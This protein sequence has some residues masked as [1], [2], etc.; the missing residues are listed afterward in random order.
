VDPRQASVIVVVDLGFGDAGKGTITDFLVRERGARAVVRFNGGAQAGHTV[1]TSDGRAHTFSQIG[2]GAFVPGVRTHLAEPFVVDPG[3]LLFEARRLETLGVPD[4]LAALTLDGR[5][6]VITPFHLAANHLRE[7]SRGQAQHG[8]CGVG[9]GETVADALAAGE[10]AVRASDL[11]DRTRLRARARRAQERLRASLPRS[12]GASDWQRVL[13]DDGALLDRWIEQAAP[14]SRCVSDG[15][16]D[17]ILASGPVVFEGAQGVLL[18]EVHGFHPH[19]T[20]SDCTPR[21]ALTLLAHHG[22]PREHTA[23]V[24]VSRTYA[25]RHGAG[26]FPSEDVAMHAARPEPHNG[27]DGAQ[28]PFRVGALDLVLLRYAARV[29][30]PIDG[31]AITHLD[32]PLAAPVVAYENAIDPRFFVHDAKMRAIDLRGGDLEHQAQLGDA[33]RAAHPCRGELAST[34]EWCA[35][36]THALS[37]PIAITSS[38]PTAAEKAWG[39]RDEATTRD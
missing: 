11:R 16:L 7:A 38:G 35:S 33:L 22:I 18:D 25:T 1:V 26:P 12:G 30:G 37:L 10:D 24:G 39:V 20:W 17:V 13:D 29:A 14:A 21:G 34:E 32:R 28:G 36:L 8:T 5:A 3:A 19:T 31:L 2:A 23:I 6:R 9:F 27:G 4:P 15:V